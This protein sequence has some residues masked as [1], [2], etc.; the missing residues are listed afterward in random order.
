MVWETKDVFVFS[1]LFLLSTT[2]L[3]V[4]L[5]LMLKTKMESRSKIMVEIFL[6]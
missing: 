4:P 2:C 6:Y 5:F 3:I 1:F